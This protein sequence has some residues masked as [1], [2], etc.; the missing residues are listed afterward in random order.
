MR[1]A[2]RAVIVAAVVA[3]PFGIGAAPAAQ[4]ACDDIGGVV[5][6]CNEGMGDVHV[7]IDGLL[8]VCVKINNLCP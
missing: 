1:R 4:A 5:T 7:H 3:L 2:L 6:V 8:H